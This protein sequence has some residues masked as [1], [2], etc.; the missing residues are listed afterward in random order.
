LLIVGQPK[1]LLQHCRQDRAWLWSPAWAT[2][3]EA[4]G[5]ALAALA[6]PTFAATLAAALTTFAAETTTAPLPLIGVQLRGQC[7]QL[8]LGHHAVLFGV[9]HLEQ[10]LQSRV[11]HLVLG[12]LA[13]LLLVKLHHLGDDRGVA[14]VLLV[15]AWVVFAFPSRRLS[16]Y[17][18]QHDGGTYHRRQD[19]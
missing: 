2:P 6:K 18:R 15:L 10:P 8:F 7:H 3:T 16:R 14:V 9:R 5:S 11:G 4:A 19:P 13:V 12:Q 1:I 17:L